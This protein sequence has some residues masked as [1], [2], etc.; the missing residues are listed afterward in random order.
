[1]DLTISYKYLLLEPWVCPHRTGEGHPSADG[2]GEA[3]SIL[4]LFPAFPTFSQHL[5]AFS[6]VYPS[7]FP[8]KTPSFISFLPVA[9]FPTF[10][11]LRFIQPIQ[12]FE[13]LVLPCH[14]HP[15]VQC[16]SLLPGTQPGSAARCGAAHLSD[17]RFGGVA[18]L[19]EFPAGAENWGVEP[20]FT[21][22]LQHEL[23]PEVWIS[24]ILSMKAIC[25]Q[26]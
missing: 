8:N 14:L 2:D 15:G 13:F 16:H 4:R 10:F 12:Q 21:W 18:E 7:I 11:N 3:A 9:I 26:A 6:E 1:M 20:V 25:F 19:H 23:G 5:L 24:L 17:A 22:H